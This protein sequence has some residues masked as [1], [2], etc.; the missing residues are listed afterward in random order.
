LTQASKHCLNN[1][2]TL[3]IPPLQVYVNIRTQNYLTRVWGRT[4]QKG[5]VAGTSALEDLCRTIFGPNT[6]CCPGYPEP[7]PASDFCGDLV[8]VDYPFP[9]KISRSCEVL[10]QSDDEWAT[11]VE[12]CSMCSVV[13]SELTEESNVKV[14]V[15]EL[16]DVAEDFFKVEEDDV[17]EVELEEEDP[18]WEEKEPISKEPVVRKRNRACKSQTRDAAITEEKKSKR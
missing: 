13:K 10:H 11:T 2:Y 17:F 3:R 16:M 7:D 5:Q 8:H 18:D 14:D 15:D 12:L 1:C 4:R 6:A 9:R